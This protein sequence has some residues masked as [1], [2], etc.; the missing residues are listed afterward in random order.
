MHDHAEYGMI[1]PLAEEYHAG[2][3]RKHLGSGHRSLNRNVTF[4]LP[5]R[6]AIDKPLR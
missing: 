2:E 1:M 5:T 6:A 3:Y 4:G